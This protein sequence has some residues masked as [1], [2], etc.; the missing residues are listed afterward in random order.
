VEPFKNAFNPDTVRG[1][2]TQLLQVYPPF[3]H[4]AFT[5][6]GIDGIEDLELKARVDHLAHTLRAYLP[7]DVPTAL[8]VLVA[9]LDAPFDPGVPNSGSFQTWPIARFVAHY[10]TEVPEQALTALHA[11]TQRFTGEFAIRPLI[12]QHTEVTL[13]T[14]HTWAED[15][16][17]HVRRL[18][19]EGTRTRLPWGQRLH[20]FIDDPTPV[21]PLLERLRTDPSEYVRRSVANN[22]NDLAK[23][24]PTLV[25]DTCARWLK[26]VPSPQLQRLVRHA[27]RTLIKRGDS[28]AL[29]TLGYAP[30]TAATLHNLLASSHVTLGGALE[31][32]CEVHNPGDSPTPLVIDFVIHHVRANG[33][34][35]PKVFKWTT[36]I[37][38]PGQR[39]VLR[40]RH[41]M[42]PVTTRRY[43]AGEHL[44]EVQING[45]VRASR[46][47]AFELVDY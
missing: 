42:K 19:S 12:K 16:S 41:R 4:E 43:Y 7:Q 25:V 37:L 36:T 47:F 44:V 29:R 34:R 22:L 14:L 5:R 17:E 28:G 6:D 24:H 8:D 30:D 39:K 23:D 21:M 46:A 13:A 9:T 11:I 2:S 38:K 33:E 1:L 40:K 31:L 32:S 27:L 10:G 26:E 18:V 15:P 20:Q 35:S 45:R 3:D